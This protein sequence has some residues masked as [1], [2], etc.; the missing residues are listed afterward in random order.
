MLPSV[1]RGL[2]RY[3][4]FHLNHVGAQCHNIILQS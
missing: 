2:D 3:V 1:A 4:K